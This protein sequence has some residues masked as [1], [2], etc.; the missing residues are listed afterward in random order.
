MKSTV[1]CG[2][3]GQGGKEP[4]ALRGWVRCQGCTSSLLC[5]PQGLWVEMMVLESFS[6][7]NDS[8][9]LVGLGGYGG[10]MA[11]V[12]PVSCET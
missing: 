4:V 1:T 6:I 10:N 12:S 5:S 8:V 2:Q 9:V 11:L 7:L 3:K